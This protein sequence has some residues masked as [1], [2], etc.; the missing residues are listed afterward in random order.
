MAGFISF[1][2][3]RVQP[4]HKGVT[5]IGAQGSVDMLMRLQ[6]CDFLDIRFVYRVERLIVDSRALVK[7]SGE[8]NRHAAFDIAGMCWCGRG[9]LARG[10]WTLPRRQVARDHTGQL[11]YNRG[12][13]IL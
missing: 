5:G 2:C 9:R 8:T 13:G 11:A 7:I 4:V 3:N 10:F 12:G 1:A 6:N